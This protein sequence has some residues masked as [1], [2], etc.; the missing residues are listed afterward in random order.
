[1]HAGEVELGYLAHPEPG[2]RPGVVLIHDVWG[3]SEHTRDLARRVAGEG[4]AAL[5]VNLYRRLPEVRLEDPA[6]FIRELSDPQALEEVQAGIDFLAAHPAV[7]GHRVGVV[8]F[9]MGGMYALL[10][11]AGCRGLSAAAVFYGLLSHARGMLAAPGLDPERKPREPVAAAREIGCPLLALF[12]E[13]D[14]L[15]LLEDVQRL[16]E[17]LSGASHPAEIV[18]Y[19]GAGHAFMNDTRPAAYRPDT[20]RRAWSRLLSFLRHELR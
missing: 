8:G 15:V 5:A 3:L 7:A 2:T 9:C 12:G 19:P 13:D 6:R 4:F 18:V 20:A 17:S 16:R 11:A 1:V 10:A 14:E